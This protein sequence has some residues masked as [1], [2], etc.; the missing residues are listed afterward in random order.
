MFGIGVQEM[1]F[2]AVIALLV[3]GPKRLP[4]LARTLGKGL[5]EFRRASSDLRGAL[6]LDPDPR[7]P[8]PRSQRKQ[9]EADPRVDRDFEPRPDQ[10][11]GGPDPAAEARVLAELADEANDERHR[12][13]RA[14][15]P[16]AA[17]AEESAADPLPSETTEP[18][19]EGATTTNEGP[20]RSGRSD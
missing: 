17:S 14:P 18:G 8:Q 1:M 19:P 3:F 2:L 10:A 20:E 6:S 13:A 12:D 4:E 7:S 16:E 9:E 5:A 11:V 15:E